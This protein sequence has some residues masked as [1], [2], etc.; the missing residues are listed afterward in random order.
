[1]QSRK[2]A[3]D[4][5]TD[6]AFDAASKALASAQTALTYTAYATAARDNSRLQD[7]DQ[8]K[9]AFLAKAL[10]AAQRATKLSP[11][12]ENLYLLGD[13]QEDSGKNTEALAS[14][15]RAFG[16]Q[17]TPT[18]HWDALRGM[19]RSSRVLNRKTDAANWFN[20]LRDS[21]AMNDFDWKTQADYLSGQKE[22]REAA[23]IYEAL[24]SKSDRR[25]R[26]S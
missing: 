16:G 9:A 14:F 25:F 5:H 2:A 7:D 10:D 8:Q 12:P 13:I 15:T 21:G 20:Q 1:L 22:Y 11:T 18:E 24:A 17:L 3:S 6:I 26:F 23:A 4:W 19:I